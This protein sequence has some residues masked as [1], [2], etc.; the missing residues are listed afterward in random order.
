[1][2]ETSAAVSAAQVVAS[3]PPTLPRA[4]LPLPPSGMAL[5][6]DPE[7]ASAMA[8]VLPPL[9]LSPLP[10]TDLAAELRPPLLPVAMTMGGKCITTYLCDLRRLFMGALS[11]N[12]TCGASGALPG[13]VSVFV[14]FS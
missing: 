2:V 10:I 12:L 6:V 11:L 3:A 13:K 14:A 1:M 7:A 4:A 8:S 9:P 5:A